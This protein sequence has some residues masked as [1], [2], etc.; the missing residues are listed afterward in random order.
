MTHK[1]LTISIIIATFLTAEVVAAGS[2]HI[3]KKSTREQPSMTPSGLYP[4]SEGEK[5]VSE[6]GKGPIM[7]PKP[8]AQTADLKLYHSERYGYEI[9]YPSEMTVHH[10]YGGQ[11]LRFMKDSDLYFWITIIDL[12]G[13]VL[14][15]GKSRPIK[16]L[17][18]R[19][20]LMI[21]LTQR[22]KNSSVQTLLLRSIRIGGIEGL[23]AFT[24][25]D[26]C[27]N[28]YLPWT[29]VIRNGYCYNFFMIR[30]SIKTYR[31]LLLNFKFI[32]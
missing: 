17:P 10:P 9:E 7:T 32:K 13:S 16:T 11:D 31:E 27:I 24:S 29:S 22:C 15:H 2:Y 23:Q 28:Q 21:N 1:K 14:W 30:G 19:D 6:G 3:A 12:K 20:Q 25:D 5:F 18:L 4:Q 26:Q 8:T